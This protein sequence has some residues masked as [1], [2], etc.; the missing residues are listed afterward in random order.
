MTK[1][2]IELEKSVKDYNT[3]KKILDSGKTSPKYF[4][5]YDDVEFRKLYIRQYF[6]VLKN[7][8]KTIEIISNPI[9][10]NVIEHYVNTFYYHQSKIELS[11]VLKIHND[12]KIKEAVLIKLYDDGYDM[13]FD[14]KLKKY[15][16]K[17]PKYIS[18]KNCH[19]IEDMITK[20]YAIKNICYLHGK[21]DKLYKLLTF[22]EY[23][24]SDNI[25]NQIKDQYYY[26]YFKTILKY[27]HK[28]VLNYLLKCD[29]NINITYIGNITDKKQLSK[30][31]TEN[32]LKKIGINTLMNLYKLTFVEEYANKFI[33]HESCNEYSE[34]INKMILDN[35]LD[36]KKYYY[37]AFEKINLSDDA[38][39]ILY[40]NKK[41]SFS[42]Y[43]KLISE[44]EIEKI[45]NYKKE[46]FCFIYNKIK[47]SDDRSNKRNHKSWFNGPDFGIPNLKTRKLERLLFKIVDEYELDNKFLLETFNNMENMEPE[48]LLHMLLDSRTC[49]QW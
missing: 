41:I 46:V 23:V 14:E 24:E 37:D 48:I 8:E 16:F 22:E 18:D 31:H 7:D 13:I 2:E 9:Y 5:K 11:H 33:Q 40:K 6:D 15:I 32:L 3:I 4:Y 35:K 25:N 34:E 26:I 19:F 1:I 27:K 49:F 36:M 45:I 39:K 42:K 43:K 38:I 30:K 28:E 12:L 47:N 17:N 21:S 20:E 29:N 44:E 10:K